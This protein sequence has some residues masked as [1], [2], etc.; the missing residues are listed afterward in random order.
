M[1]TMQTTLEALELLSTLTD[2]MLITVN[3][4][5]TITTQITADILVRTMVEEVVAMVE[6]VIA[7]EEHMEGTLR[8]TQITAAQTIH[9]PTN[10]T[11][12]PILIVIGEGFTQRRTVTLQ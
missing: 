10:D 11:L 3:T 6:A 2:P 12:R 5:K 8:L 1:Q 9:E 7:A 4:L